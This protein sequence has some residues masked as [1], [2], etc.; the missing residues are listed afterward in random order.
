MINDSASSYHVAAAVD[1]FPETAQQ[2]V[3]FYQRDGVNP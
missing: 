2:N 3:L 1:Y